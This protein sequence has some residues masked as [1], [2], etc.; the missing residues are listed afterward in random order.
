MQHGVMPELNINGKLHVNCTKQVLAT[1]TTASGSSRLL[2]GL[3]VGG[4]YTA[5]YF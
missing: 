1:S 2:G 4:W 3:E 5:Y